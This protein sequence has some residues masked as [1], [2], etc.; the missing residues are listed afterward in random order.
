MRP[1]GATAVPYGHKKDPQDKHHLVVV[2]VAGAVIIRIF[3]LVAEGASTHEVARI[4]NTEQVPTPSQHKADT[5]SFH[6]NWTGGNFWIEK[7]VSWIVRDC[8]YIPHPAAVVVQQV[9]HRLQEALVEETLE[10]RDGIPAG[11][12]RVAEPGEAVFDA[13]SRWPLT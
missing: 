9:L 10:E 4:L 1:D 11:F 13:Q 7:M 2:P 8:Q 12:F 6:A 3:T 5:P